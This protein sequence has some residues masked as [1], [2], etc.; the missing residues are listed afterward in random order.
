MASKAEEFLKNCKEGKIRSKDTK[1]T[2]RLIEQYR[3]EN[4]ED[5][6]VDSAPN[7]AGGI[8]EE[9]WTDDILYNVTSVL[10]QCPADNKEWK[11]CIEAFHAALKDDNIG[12][13]FIGLMLIFLQH[14]EN[15]FELRSDEESDGSGTTLNDLLLAGECSK[16]DYKFERSEL[17][18][19]QLLGQDT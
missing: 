13:S 16:T 12:N 11:L 14:V 9:H 19:R 10:I 1:T 8:E 18:C 2:T 6:D 15:P 17:I 3:L 4:Q 5:E 7:F